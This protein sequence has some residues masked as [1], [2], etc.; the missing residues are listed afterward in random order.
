ML[1]KTIEFNN[2]LQN[3]D[4]KDLIVLDESGCYLGMNLPYARAKGGARVKMPQSFVRGTKISMIGAISIDKVEAAIY[5]E[6]NTDSEIFT[7]YVEQKLVPTLSAGKVVIMDNVRFHCS[8]E[9]KNLIEGTGAR[10]LF[11]PPYTPELSPIEPMWGKVKQVLK[12]YSPKSIKEFAKYIKVAFE[13]I[14]SDDLTGW[15]SHCGYSL[16]R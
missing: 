10:I 12:K 2:A 13:S 15:F 4:T 8:E 6:W 1:K 3:I 11:L 16:N 5:G 7:A 9:V 14:T